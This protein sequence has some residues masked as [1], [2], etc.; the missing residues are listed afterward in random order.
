MTISSN[1]RRPSFDRQAAA[2]AAANKIPVSQPPPPP[3]QPAAKPMTTNYLSYP[4]FIQQQQQQTSSNI[5]SQNP[6]ISST[7]VTT[8]QLLTD[9]QAILQK[10]RPVVPRSHFL[11]LN[12]V[13]PTVQPNEQISNS[14]TDEE[15]QL[16]Q[17]FVD[18]WLN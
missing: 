7:T 9:P 5:S 10:L 6:A 13:Q 17:S 2:P 3:R 11:G 14:V 18:A 12:S 4:Q 1:G 16:D 15:E 8:N